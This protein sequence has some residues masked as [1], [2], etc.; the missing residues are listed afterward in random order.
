MFCMYMRICIYI[1]VLLLAKNNVKFIV[2]FFNSSS[3]T[4]PFHLQSEHRESD[5]INNANM[6]LTHKQS[7]ASLVNIPMV[8][9]FVSLQMLYIYIYLYIYIF[10]CI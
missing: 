3:C 5:K 1:D 7:E 10:I 4:V 8:H 2:T 9:L 6:L